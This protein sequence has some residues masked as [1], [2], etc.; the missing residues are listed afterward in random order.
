[1]P[2][3]RAKRVKRNP[4]QYLHVTMPP[5]RGSLK[6]LLAN[7]SDTYKLDLLAMVATQL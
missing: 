3:I 7:P 1:M 2:P 6:E 5:K 4:S